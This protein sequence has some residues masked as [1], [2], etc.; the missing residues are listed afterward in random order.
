MFNR[1]THQSGP[2]LQHPK[3]V[4][5]PF[6]LPAS[7][8]IPDSQTFTSNQSNN[9]PYGHPTNDRIRTSTASSSDYQRFSSPPATSNELDQPFFSNPSQAPQNNFNQ[10]QNSPPNPHHQHHLQN[11]QQNAWPNPNPIGIGPSNN[12]SNP[13]G[14]N[15]MT[16]QMGMQFG[17]SAMKAGSEYV[18]KNASKRTNQELYNKN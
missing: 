11:Q 12:F 8:P 9:N 7:P 16:A 17:Q 6:N 5:P 3:P 15:D 4:P 13:F 14:V 1:N 18:E 10:F 2:T